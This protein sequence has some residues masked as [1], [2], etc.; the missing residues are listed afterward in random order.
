MLGVICFTVK[1]YLHDPKHR[2]AMSHFNSSFPFPYMSI[3]EL[4]Q[5]IFMRCSKNEKCNQNSQNP[6]A[7]CLFLEEA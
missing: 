5:F 1:P 2:L 7:C 3:S 6:F 4:Y